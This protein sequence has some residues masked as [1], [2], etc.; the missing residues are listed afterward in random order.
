MRDSLRRRRSGSAVLEFALTFVVLF[1]MM[2]G[3]F[4]FGYAFFL[5]NQ[6]K[7][8]VREGSRYASLAT[9]D[10]ST[11]AYTDAYGNAVKNMVVYGSPSGGTQSLVPRLNTAHVRVAVTF[12]RGVPASV[13]VRVEN[14]PL[15][16]GFKTLL[17][18][19][20]SCTFTYVGRYAPAGL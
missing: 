8:A 4:E 20:P 7:N 10:S 11:A 3:V 5:Y 19:K 16:T 15:D 12:A 6:L 1:P 2:M 17:L 14:Y 13:T 9:Y 18:H